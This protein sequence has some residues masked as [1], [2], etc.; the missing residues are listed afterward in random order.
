MLRQVE[1]GVQSGAITKNGVLPVTNL[2]F[3]KFCFV[4]RPSYKELI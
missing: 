3:R 2:F 4:I 1:W